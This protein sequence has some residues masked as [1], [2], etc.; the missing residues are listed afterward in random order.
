MEDVGRYKKPASCLLLVAFPLFLYIREMMNKM[1]NN[2]SLR[3]LNYGAITGVVL[4]LVILGFYFSGN[5]FNN[6][7]S[8]FSFISLSGCLMITM[9][10]YRDKYMDGVMNYL[11]ALKTGFRISFYAALVVGFTYYLLYT[12]DRGLLAQFITAST[13]ALGDVE[14]DSRAT[15]LLE[16]G[17]NNI[18]PLILAIAHIIE[19]TFS[20][21]LLSLVLSFLIRKNEQQINIK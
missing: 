12:I 17:Q 14:L 21:F 11:Q 5:L 4:C 18:T 3:V 19:V 1:T 10:R 15:E 2:S 20:G 9:R 7:S 16:E 6:R 8:F 13:E